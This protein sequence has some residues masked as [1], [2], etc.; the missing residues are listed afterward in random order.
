M[1]QVNQHIEVRPNNIKLVTSMVSIGVL[2][3]LVI[4]L[5]FQG[6]LGR[7]EM[8]QRGALEK[9][10]FHVL[11]G[12]SSTQRCVLTTD[13]QLL[14]AESDAVS[15]E[16]IFQGFDQDGQLVGYA[17]PAEG[18]G[19]ADIIK[20]LYGYVP[21]EGAIVGIQVLESKETPGLGDKIEK[22]QRFLANFKSLDVSMKEDGTGLKNKIVL[23]KPGEKTEAWE[24]DGITGA[25]ISSRAIANILAESGEK[26]LPII[27]HSKDLEETKEEKR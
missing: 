23:V 5:T 16:E 15:G 13:D 19:Y 6:T 14:Q 11:P 8:N 21:R 1:N 9:A 10:I 4:V 20:I 12:V 18:Q 22:D 26:W 24:V 2:C 27:H 7:I 17:I 3:A 25:T